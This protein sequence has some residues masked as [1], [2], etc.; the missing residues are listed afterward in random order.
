M[1]RVGIIS[2]DQNP[3]DKI[4]RFISCT[5]ASVYCKAG[6]HEWVT[7]K[8]TIRELIPDSTPSTPLQKYFQPKQKHSIILEKINPPGP[9]TTLV[10]AYPVADQSSYAKRDFLLTWGCSQVEWQ[11]KIGAHQTKEKFLESWGITEDV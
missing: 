1:S 7:K 2:F 10:L 11:R 8:K 3:N 6:T 5:T 4:Y 9:Q